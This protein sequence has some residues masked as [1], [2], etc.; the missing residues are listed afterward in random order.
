[1]N[2]SDVEM[3]L[4]PVTLSAFLLLDLPLPLSQNEIAPKEAIPTVRCPYGVGKMAE[5]ESDCLL[6]RALVQHVKMAL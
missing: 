3:M 6:M 1:M 4:I 2:W 5:I